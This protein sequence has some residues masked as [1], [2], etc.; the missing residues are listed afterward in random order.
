MRNSTGKLAT[1]SL[2]L[3][4]LVISTLLFLASGAAASA[5]E[6]NRGGAVLADAFRAD[7]IFY[8]ELREPV[9]IVDRF[10]RMSFWPHVVSLMTEAAGLVGSSERCAR[11]L[12]FALGAWG[13]ESE[14][15]RHVARLAGA[16]CAIG[17]VPIEGSKKVVPLF[18]FERTGGQ[19]VAA[20]RSRP[21]PRRGL[22]APDR[23]RSARRCAGRTVLDRGSRGPA[24]SRG[25]RPRPVARAQ[26]T[27][28]LR[29]CQRRDQRPRSWRRVDR[30]APLGRGGLSDGHV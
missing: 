7:T 11:N 21:R 25:R 12:S 14:F 15:R 24:A 17:L 29:P 30:S 13:E 9:A 19:P 1:Q 2:P 8:A 4:S 20:H 10:S 23:R 3:G 18:V 28:R 27:C 5:D 26:R 16:R 6:Q 22:E